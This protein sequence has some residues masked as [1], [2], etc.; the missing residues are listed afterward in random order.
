MEETREESERKPSGMLQGIAPDS[1][2]GCE[3]SELR[4]N[5]TASRRYPA[6]HTSKAVV[7]NAG[8]SGCQ[9][10]LRPVPTDCG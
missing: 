3:R 6:A 9:A 5:R 4:H 1:D 2:G 10:F 7:N 8:R